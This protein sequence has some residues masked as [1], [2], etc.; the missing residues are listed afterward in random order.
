M[1]TAVFKEMIAVVRTEQQRR[2]DADRSTDEPF[3]NEHCL[4]L[5]VALWHQVERELVALAARAAD[6]GKEISRERYQ[7]NVHRLQEELR[8]SAKQGWKTIGGRLSHKSCQEYTHMEVLRS[9]ANSYKHHPSMKPND[10]LLK[11]LKKELLKLTKQDTG[12]NYG[13]LPD[14]WMLQQALAA[15]VG[16]DRCAAYCDIAEQLV[17]K[18][19]AFLEDV[20]SRAKVSPVE[21]GPM[22]WN[23]IEV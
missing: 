23:D 10:E 18:A 17:D 6:D 22:T 20:R 1:E 3:F 8:K 9:L 11:L 2:A 21:W 13:R 15:F 19:S 7:K 16:L 12:V 4:M 5:L 14:S